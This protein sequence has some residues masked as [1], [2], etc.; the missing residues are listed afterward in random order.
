MAD[1]Y[2]FRTFTAADLP[3]ME[4]WLARP[5]VA[6][7]WG[8]PAEQLALVRED[9]DHPDMDQYLVLTG[10][11]PFAYLQCYTLGVWNEGFGLQPAGSRG[12]DQSIGEPDMV[13]C[14]HGTAFIRQFV[15][16]LF[17]RGIPR[18][19]TDPIRRMRAP[20]GVMRKLA[21][22]VIASSIR[23]MALHC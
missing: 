21:L 15:R 7:W 18:V 11:K 8:D 16:G 14:G 1:T 3:L 20:S 13:S 19:L 17:A 5:H 22:S 23:P 12:I 4:Q 10:G 9:I 2:E 6:E